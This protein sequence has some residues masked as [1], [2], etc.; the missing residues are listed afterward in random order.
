MNIE[1]LVSG[2]AGFSGISRL[3]DIDNVFS[4]LSGIQYGTP[5][6]EDPQLTKPRQ[7]PLVTPRPWTLGGAPGN[8]P[9][10]L[11]TVTCGR[12]SANEKVVAILRVR[13]P[14]WFSDSRKFICTG[15]ISLNIAMGKSPIG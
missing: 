14:I 7:V 3:T 5:W 15:P 9:F 10:Q 11:F 1:S 8:G 12:P 2:D 4:V 6:A 13:A